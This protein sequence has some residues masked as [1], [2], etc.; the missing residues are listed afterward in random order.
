MSTYGDRN[1]APGETRSV[2]VLLAR[3]R[4]G[5]RG[6][7]IRHDNEPPDETLLARRPLYYI[8]F[9]LILFSGILRQP[10]LIVA[11]LFVLV[12]AVIPELWY[13][14]C[15][16][17]LTI[18]RQPDTKRA[19]LGDTIEIVLTV[20][21]RKPLPLPWFEIVDEIPES[22]PVANLKI[23]QSAK[24]ERALLANTFSLWAYQRVRRR[25]SIRALTRG[26]YRFGPMILRA[27]DPFG[28]LTRE[29]SIDEPAVLVVHPLVAP[30]ERFGLPA[31]APFGERK[32]TRRVLEDP[33]RIS[34][35][36]AYVP[37]DEPR[38]IHWKATARMGT[39]QS[40][41]YEP[42]TIHTLS[43][44][45]D[46]RTL[47]QA[48]MSYDPV[49]VELHICA[50]ASV[51]DWAI[52]LRYAVGI[53]A[54]G[55]LGVPEFAERAP[56]QSSLEGS[57]AE[58]VDDQLQRE[59]ER[60]RAALRLRIPASS[61]PEQLTRIFD[62]LARLLPYHGLPMEQVIRAEER[63]LSTGATVVYV[64]TENLVDVPLIIALRRLKS[65]GHA[66]SL[67]LTKS[68]QS[69]RETAEHPHFAGLDTHYIGGPETW[70]ELLRDT[71][72]QD[73]PG[74]F[75]SPRGARHAYYGSGTDA[76]R[77]QAGDHESQAGIKPVDARGNGD[78]NGKVTE[79]A[80]EVGGR[81]RSRSLVVE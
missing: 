11:G 77:R 78:G 71:L 45:L 39:L 4:L 58:S 60:T 51:A 28:I 52:R 43:I 20:E 70:V 56:R 6:F 64:G 42:S 36:R 3:A 73:A 5:Y 18:N 32:G 48:L 29:I 67:L 1:H 61:R 50:A 15:L 17:Q 49:L 76:A 74:V 57:A 55:T 62:S 8:A 65:H 12:L 75:H 54:N 63:E 53:F 46:T 66:V 44:F 47:S 14:Y 38:R 37:G 80:G 79:P 35:I 72:G 34:G 68:S 10:L 16:R 2:Y 33:L 19:A 13:R 21:N 22:L 81:R 25:Y 31:L 59:I 40:K 7:R 23:M 30:L 41:T 9:L 27:T 24:P 26:A 69:E